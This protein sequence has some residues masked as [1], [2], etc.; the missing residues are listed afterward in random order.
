[1]LLFLSFLFVLPLSWS[2][3]VENCR[4]KQSD[5][6][7]V[8]RPLTF[9]KRACFCVLVD[10]WKLLVVFVSLVHCRRC[11]KVK[12]LEKGNVAR[13]LNTLLSPCHRLRACGFELSSR[14]PFGCLKS[15]LYAKQNELA[16]KPCLGCC[17]G[18]KQAAGFSSSQGYISYCVCRCVRFW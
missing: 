17:R 18:H 3:V 2:F 12:V 6:A 8:A 15:A 7:H 14:R 16:R 4:S 1:M 10:R 9:G 13:L 5:R 11:L